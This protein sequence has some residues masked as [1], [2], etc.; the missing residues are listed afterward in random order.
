MPIRKV[1]TVLFISDSDFFSFLSS[2]SAIRRFRGD[3][4]S[5]NVIALE[6]EIRFIMALFSS[7]PTAAASSLDNISV[8]NLSI[9]DVSS[10]VSDG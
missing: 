2:M 8:A 1:D 4:L 9:N 6:R 7:L 5:T 10:S 3:I